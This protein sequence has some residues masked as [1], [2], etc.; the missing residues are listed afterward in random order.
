MKKHSQFANLLEITLEAIYP[1]KYVNRKYQYE[2]FM[3]SYFISFVMFA[4]PLMVHSSEAFTLT[5]KID[6]PHSEPIYVAIYE[7]EETFLDVDDAA[8][9]KKFLVNEHG[10]Y[11]INLVSEGEYALSFFQDVNNNGEFD[12]S[13]LG[14]PEE[15]FGVSNNPISNFGPPSYSDSKFDLNSNLTIQ[16]DLR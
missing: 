3:K 2:D 1:Y 16:I 13:F 7:N 11:T 6:S 5:L 15:P 14:M 10:S 12:T 8:I 4:F 9:K